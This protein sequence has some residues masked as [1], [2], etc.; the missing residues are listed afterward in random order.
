V[1]YVLVTGASGYI[2]QHLVRSLIADGIRVRGFG[3]RPPPDGW[4]GSD[5]Q[6]GDICC[7]GHVNQAVHGCDTVIHLACHPLGQSMQ[8]PVSAFRVNA[9]GTLH[10]LHAAHAA[11]VR[12][13]VYSSTAQVYGTAP[14]LPQREED[15]PQPASPYAA[16]KWRGEI[17]CTTF[18]RC[19]GLGTTILRLFNVYGP[20]LD[21]RDRTTA[22]A[23]FIRR[24]LRGLPPAIQGDPSAGRDFIHMRDVVQAIKQAAQRHGMGRSSISARAR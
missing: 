11:G 5:W 10:I 1:I 3:S 20:A 18:A 16:S 7:A 14:H 17:L 9:L 19:Y 22:E 2:G 4:P 8:D 21:G 13:V 12:Q 6:Q 24:A 15:P 23:Q